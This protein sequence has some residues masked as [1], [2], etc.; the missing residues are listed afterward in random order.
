[1]LHTVT[2]HFRYTG[3][4][5]AK[6]LI[7][8]FTGIITGAFAVMMSKSVNAITEWR[9]EHIQEILDEGRK[10]RIF[11]AYLWNCAFSSGLVILATAMV[12]GGLVVCKTC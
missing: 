4:T 5:L 3:K 11:V 6:F 1:M 10:S 9:L 8:F 7:T 2:F 12:Q